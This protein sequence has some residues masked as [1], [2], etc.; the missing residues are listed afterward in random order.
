MFGRNPRLPV[1]VSLGLSPNDS[2]V[3]GVPEY[4]QKFKK[5]MQVAYDIAVSTAKRAGE[6]SK[7][8]YDAKVREV[9]LEP[10][11]RVLLKNVAF[12]GKHKL[13]NHWGEFVYVVLEHPNETIP[14]F[15]VRKE[16]GT[17]PKKTLHRNMLLSLA[18][19]PLDREV[20]VKH[21]RTVRS[22]AGR[23][24]VDSS[25]SSSSE[26]EDQFVV[27]RITRS[28][29]T[30]D[31]QECES[32][33]ED[34]HSDS[35]DELATPQTHPEMVA[36]VACS[37]VVVP[38]EVDTGVASS[39]EDVHPE[40][41][42]ES[43]TPHARPEEPPDAGDSVDESAA[44]QVHPEE[45]ADASFSADETQSEGA[46][47]APIVTIPPTPAPR[48]SKRVTKPP[49]WYGYGDGQSHFPQISLPSS[50]TLEDKVRLLLQAKSEFPSEAHSFKDAIITLVRNAD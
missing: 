21:T 34:V 17:G 9:K 25:D 38:Q 37:E 50:S 46:L 42:V 7:K 10:G 19:I 33:Q 22:K 30:V 5:T 48:R 8:R 12:Q 35:V 45:P 3:E 47:D 6:Q 2:R 41:V 31:P 1:D 44:P 26:D 4:V 27:Q 36:E 24:E 39:Q 13:A 23:S 28:H 32:F 11:D 40:P 18:T 43:A 49:D 16:D 20:K 29:A 15:V 14:V